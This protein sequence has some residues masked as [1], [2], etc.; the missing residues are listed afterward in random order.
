MG[1]T[2]SCTCS[3]A[4]GKGEIRIVDYLDREEP[5]LAKM[6]EKRMRGS[7]GSYESETPRPPLMT[8]DRARDRANRAR[9]PPPPEARQL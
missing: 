4:P 2:R 5:V 7:R 6:F 9:I 3:A 1:I 8:T